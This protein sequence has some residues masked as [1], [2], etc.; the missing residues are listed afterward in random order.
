[1]RTYAT[2]GHPTDC[3]MAVAA[4]FYDLAAPSYL[5]E[6]AC[7]VNLTTEFRLKLRDAMGIA[8]A[9]QQPMAISWSAPFVECERKALSAAAAMI[10]WTEFRRAPAPVAIIVDRPDSQQV[11]RL[12]RYEAALA[13]IPLDYEYIRPGADISRYVAVFDARQ[14]FRKP[15]IG[16]TIP[17]T[18]V[19]AAPLSF[20]E[21]SH[22]TYAVSADRRWLLAYV[23]NA[24][25]YEMKLCDVGRE[26]ELCRLADRKRSL[27]IHVKG[28]AA[29]LEYAVLD[30]QS[31]TVVGKGRFDRGVIIEL[32]ETADD[33]VL[34]VR[35]LQH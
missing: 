3:F 27:R 10:D 16:K 13:A 35:P 21:G 9:L 7:G 15:E 29:G 18:A 33:F 14:D 11:E 32:G 6:V 34:V 19:E 4:R 22:A 26:V 20:T 30:C 1:Y 2:Y 25:H 8:F 24:T 5:G 28:M 12:V 17:D 23:R 31:A